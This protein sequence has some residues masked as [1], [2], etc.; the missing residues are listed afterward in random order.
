MIQTY[1]KHEG[2]KLLGILN[3]ETGEVYVEDHKSYDAQV[4][5]SFL[6]NVLKKYPTGD[7]VMILDNAKIHHAKLLTNFLLANSR[8]HLEFLLPYSPNLNLIEELWGWLKSTV[9]NN[10]FFHTREDI[11]R[12]VQSF[13]DYI[14]SIPLIVIDRLCI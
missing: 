13:I 1:G 5:Q 12:A 10:V 7:I 6:T 4:F 8:L 2:V 11:K 9:I 3:D 14:A